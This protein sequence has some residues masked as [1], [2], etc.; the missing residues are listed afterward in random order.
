M[1]VEE[2]IVK[3]SLWRPT[4]NTKSSPRT[5]YCNH[6]VLLCVRKDTAIISCEMSAALPYVRKKDHGT[7][8]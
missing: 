3:I 8:Y 6:K 7:P 2:F 1:R 5:F 4:K